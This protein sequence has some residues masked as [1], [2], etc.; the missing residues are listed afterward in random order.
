MVKE[1]SKEALTLLSYLLFYYRATIKY[2]RVIAEQLGS[3][4]CNLKFM[5]SLDQRIGQNFKS[6]ASFWSKEKF[7]LSLKSKNLC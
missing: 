5:M 6:L 2:I 1:V 7:G 3:F 4:L